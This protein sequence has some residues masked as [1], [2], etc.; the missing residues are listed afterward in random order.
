MKNVLTTLVIA[1]VV[2]LSGTA[3]HATPLNFLVNG[4]FGAANTK[5]PAGWTA[6][7]N[8]YEQ[9]GG[10]PGSPYYYMGNGYGDGTTY[11]SQTFTDVAGATYDLTF[12]LYSSDANQNFFSSSID[13]TALFSGTDIAGGNYIE[14]LTFLGT[15]DD[16]LRFASYAGGAFDLS[17]VAVTQAVSPTPEPESLILLGTGLVGV[18]GFAR[19]KRRRRN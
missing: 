10:G 3:A 9:V 12:T 13:G 14:S 18:A 7:N 16:T 8:R 2:A 4:N 11:L 15:G 6:T 1:G 17:N 19:G 5:V